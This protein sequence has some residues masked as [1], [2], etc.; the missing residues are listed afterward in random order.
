[1]RTK[2]ARSR[3]SGESNVFKSVEALQAM[4]AS[5]HTSLGLVKPKSITRIYMK[6]KPEGERA[7]WE[8]QRAAALQQR[9]LY[10]DAETVTHDLKFMPVQYRAC[11]VCDDPAC[12]T[13]H[14]LS[15]LDWGVYV[16]SR[17]EY[18]SR[19]PGMAEQ[20]V[21][22]KITETMD[23]AKRQP[24]FFLGNTKA[25]SRSFMIVGLFHP[26]VVKRETLPA[27]PLLPGF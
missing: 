5:D 8:E 14:D 21:I 12:S 15:I 10:V 6:K 9:E 19:G 24:Y 2:A 20:K 3:Y 7:E 16:L 26:P 1:M 13:E 22:E 17:R 25:H 11:F 23:A 27:T 18:A 4:E